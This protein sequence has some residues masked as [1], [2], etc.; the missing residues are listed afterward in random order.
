MVV[1]RGLKG[2]VLVGSL[3]VVLLVSY[4]VRAGGQDSADT[5]DINMSGKAIEVRSNH[6]MPV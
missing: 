3:L 5:V 2:L 4:S 6:K 1:E